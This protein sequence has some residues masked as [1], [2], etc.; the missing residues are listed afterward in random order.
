V[1]RVLVSSLLLVGLLAPASGAVAGPRLAPLGE[2]HPVWLGTND[3][4]SLL[5]AADLRFAE[6]AGAPVLRFPAGMQEV[7][8]DGPA[9]WHWE[10]LDP[11]F[12]RYRERGLKVIFE[13]SGAPCWAQRRPRACTGPGVPGPRH[14]R[15]WARY[16]RAFVKRYSDLIVAVEIWNEPN[17]KPF[18]PARVNPSYYARILRVS[19]PAVKAVRPDLPVL[20]G[21]L[22]PLLRVDRARAV[23]YRRFLRR[24]Y[25]AGARNHFDAI[26]FHPYAAPFLRPDYL[27][28]MR[29]LIARLTEV[30][31]RHRDA[32]IPIWI[33]EV[34]VPSAD[35]TG[36]E[37]AGR[38]AATLRTL[39]RIP[40]LRAII[41]HRMFDDPSIPLE[42]DFGLVRAERIAKPAF[43]ALARFGRGSCSPPLPIP[44]PGL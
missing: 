13:P 11:I 7:L 8:P 40:R 16:L 20:F 27:R 23:D 15:Q 6:A 30:A 28:R 36:D 34:G 21:G 5:G 39:S 14:L 44:I 41:L 9:G 12:A 43:C 33:T 26:A 31:A 37:Q 25:R 10:R 18:W 3:N 42:A 19:Y 4:W 22:A 29:W 32:G 24:A 2:P 38:I 35:L 1:R 17:L